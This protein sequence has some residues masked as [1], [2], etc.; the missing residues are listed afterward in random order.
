[1]SSTPLLSVYKRFWCPATVIVASGP[2]AM[3]IPVKRWGFSFSS[4]IL[5][6]FCYFGVLSIYY[7]LAVRWSVT[8]AF[9]AR[10]IEPWLHAIT[11]LWPTITA[12]LG[13]HLGLCGEVSIGAG[14]WI[15]EQA[16]HNNED[17]V[18]QDAECIEQWTWI[19]GGL[20]FMI[21][22]AIVLINNLLVYCHVRTTIFRMTRR[23][24]RGSSNNGS[25]S[26]T[27]ESQEAKVKAVGTQALLY[28]GV[29]I[30]TCCWTIVLRLAG[31][32]GDGPPQEPRL[33]P[34]MVL[35]A[36]F[37]PAMGL[38]T[39]LVYARPRYVLLRNAPAYK[40][41]GRAMVDAATSLVG[42]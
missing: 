24:R 16:I 27:P 1:M 41:K 18:C 19:L 32:E 17:S 10:N 14:C 20:L 38:G 39:V 28:C 31:N 40:D 15:S 6:S 26:L 30:I 12:S 13:L 35:R 23:R 9:F 5:A 37:L 33:F 36:M 34:I 2:L 7:V 29:F 3:I 22:F 21:V 42:R 25:S 8:D 11:L 4:V